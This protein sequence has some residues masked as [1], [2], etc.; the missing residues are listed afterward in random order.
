MINKN[1]LSKDGSLWLQWTLASM[2]GFA[3]GIGLGLAALEAAGEIVSFSAFGVVAGI[4]QWLVLRKIFP[5][6]GWWILATALSAPLGLVATNAIHR[7]LLGASV[8]YVAGSLG[9]AALGLVVGIAQW[10][11]MRRHLRR[12][13]WWIL[14]NLGSWLVGG[15]AAWVLGLRFTELIKIIADFALLGI[16]V[17]AST[18]LVLILLR[19]RSA[20]REDIK[21]TPL[22]NL[23][24]AGCSLVVLVLAIGS[25]QE[26]A[27]LGPVPDQGPVSGCSDLPTF[28]CGEDDAYCSELVFFEPIS[29]PGYV[30]YPVNGETWDDQYRSYLRRDLQMLIKYASARVECETDIWDYKRFEPLGLGDMSEADGSTPGTSTGHLGHPLG[31]HQDGSDIDVAYYQM[32]LEYSWLKR[33]NNGSGLEINSLVS[34]C[35]HIKFGM[36]VYRCTEPPRLL[37]TWRSAL[38]IAYLAESPYTRVI[39]VDGQIGPVLDSALD[40][41]AE[42]GWIDEDL[43]DQIP[44]SYET[45]YEGLGWFRFH[46]H[47]MH[48]SM[49]LR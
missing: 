32:D 17:G 4:A 42:A 7:V 40:Q 16:I 39:G 8:F 18:G 19:K 31:T 25:E 30:N 37:D 22:G 44:L 41:L 36:D 43:R 2:L 3:A 9:I 29:G 21:A 35:K 24:I 20:P 38:F 12:A 10:W 1:I 45:I 11:V 46:H 23:I 27:G 34:V 49:F 28:D 13:D 48:I 14:A 47:H 26:P 15:L 5:G 6:S 33:E